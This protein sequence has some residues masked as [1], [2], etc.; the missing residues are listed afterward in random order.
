MRL[1][2]NSP[3]TTIDC[4][5]LCYLLS[6][7]SYLLSTIYYLLGL[8]LIEQGALI[9][10][11]YYSRAVFMRPVKIV[12]CWLVWALVAFVAYRALHMVG[13]LEFAAT[14]SEDAP[15]PGM[16]R[17]RQ[18]T[19]AHTQWAVPPWPRRE[20]PREMEEQVLPRAL[21]FFQHPSWWSLRGTGMMD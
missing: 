10:S 21:R 5:G 15:A 1:H 11:V 17:N 9:D 18:L 4:H 12:Q 16:R 2:W 7:T 14:D 19:G 20:A 6:A 8:L 3:W 13:Q